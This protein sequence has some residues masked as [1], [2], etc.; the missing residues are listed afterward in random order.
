MKDKKNIMD[1]LLVGQDADV[2]GRI[3]QLNCIIYKNDPDDGAIIEDELSELKEPKVWQASKNDVSVK[4]WESK[5]KIKVKVSSGKYKHIS[6]KRIANI[7][8]DAILEEL[9]KED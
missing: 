2:E 3:E 5:A 7:A 6:L 9:R 1:S 8:V 4:V